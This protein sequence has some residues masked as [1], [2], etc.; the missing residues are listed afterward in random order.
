MATLTLYPTSHTGSWSNGANAMDSTSSYASTTS[1]SHVYHYYSSFKIT[2]NIPA[3]SLITQLYCYASF[4]SDT[5]SNWGY[6]MVGRISGVDQG[7]YTQWVGTRTNASDSRTYSSGDLL[8]LD[9]LTDAKFSIK[10]GGNRGGSSYAGLRQVYVTITYVE[11]KG[12]GLEMGCV[13]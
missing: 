12:V 6:G 4:V 8:N 5:S 13:F 9:N 11:T 1:Q 2:D 10:I 7:S 3:G